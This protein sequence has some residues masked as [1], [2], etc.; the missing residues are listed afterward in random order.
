MLLSVSVCMC[1][2]LYCTVCAMPLYVVLDYKKLWFKFSQAS[3]YCPTNVVLCISLRRQIVCKGPAVF[4][5]PCVGSLLPP[6]RQIC[7]WLALRV[8][9]VLYPAK[10]KVAEFLCK[11]K[12]LLPHTTLNFHLHVDPL[13]GW[14]RDTR[15][16]RRKTILVVDVVRLFCLIYF[17]PLVADKDYHDLPGKH[18]WTYNDRELLFYSS[19]FA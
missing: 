12:C 8:Y 7:R 17:F 10:S 3:S 13:C 11:F 1:T 19:K 15:A 14:M 9:W 4:M 16:Q 5:F 6:N 2:V 18:C